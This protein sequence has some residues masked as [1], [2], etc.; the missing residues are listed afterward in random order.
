[1]ADNLS[2]ARDKLEGQRRA[3]REHVEKWQRYTESYDKNTALRTIENAQRHIQNIK[4][5]FSSLRYDNRP[6]DDW[7]PGKRL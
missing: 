7:T 5:D 6:E 2:R 3:V 4:S 1:M